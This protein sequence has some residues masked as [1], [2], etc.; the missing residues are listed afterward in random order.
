MDRERAD[1]QHFGS[2]HEELPLRRAG[3]WWRDDVGNVRNRTSRDH[4]R[5]AQAALVGCRDH[6]WHVRSRC[7]GRDVSA[8]AVNWFGPGG[9]PN[10]RTLHWDRGHDTVLVIR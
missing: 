10:N 5:L 8:L 3:G 4:R 6:W 7:S 2:G 9:L 1:R